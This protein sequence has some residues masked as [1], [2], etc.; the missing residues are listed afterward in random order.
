MSVPNDKNKI[1]EHYDVVSPYYYKLWGEHLHHGYW[2]RG[3]ESKEVAQL[4]LIQYLAQLAEIPPKASILDLGCGYGGSSIFLC[5]M[6]QAQTTG[7]T[8]SPVQVEMATAAAARSGVNARFLLMDAEVLKF[9]AQFDVLWSVE[10]ISHY[11]DREQFFSSAAKFLR[12]GG[13][14]A[15]TDWFKKPGL[16]SGDVTKYIEPIERGMF[17]RLEEIGDYLS[18]LRAAGLEIIQNEELTEHC[19]KTWEIGAEIITEKS[20]WGLAAKYGTDFIQYLKGFQA[21]REGF[22]SGAFVYGLLVARKPATSS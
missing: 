4:Q 5:Q 20:F 2:R 10:S 11:H 13:T 15:L 6:Y 16:S 8:I 9:D 17:V 14:F 1:I 19:R 21:M 22:S 18:Y 3:D 7:I 12:P